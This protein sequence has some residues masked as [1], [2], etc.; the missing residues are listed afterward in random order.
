MAAPSFYIMSG[1]KNLLSDLR[2]FPVSIQSF[3]R[4]DW[5]QFFTP[6]P[7]VRTKDLGDNAKSVFREQR[8]CQQK[9]KIPIYSL[10]KS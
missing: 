4:F 2:T 3:L 7:K 9:K 8:G 5:H 10:L 6:D 1:E